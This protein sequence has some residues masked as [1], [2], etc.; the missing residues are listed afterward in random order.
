MVIKRHIR[1]NQSIKHPKRNWPP[2]L[3][4]FLVPSLLFTSYFFYRGVVPF[5]HS[6]ILTV[7]LGQQYIDFFAFYRHNLFTHPSNLLFTFSKGLGGTL[8]GTFAYYLTSP[9]NL[10]VFL[11]PESQLPGAIFVIIS[12]KIGLIGLTG[13]HYFKR[14]FN[15]KQTRIALALAVSYA[16]S[17]YVI[18]NNFNLMWLDSVILLPLLVLAVDYLVESPTIPSSGIH[19]YNLL[20]VLSLTWFTNFYTGMMIILFTTLYFLIRLC[21]YSHLKNKG[22]RWQKLRFYVVQ[23]FFS[24]MLNAVVLLPTFLELLQG[25]AKSTENIFNLNFSVQPQNLLAKLFSGSFDFDEMSQGMPNFYFGA[26]LLVFLLAYFLC[27]QFPIR[28]RLLN[29]GLIVFLLLSMCFDPL[30]LLWHSGQFPT[31]YP[32]RFSFV[33]SFFALILVAKYLEYWQSGSAKL[34][35]NKIK[36]IG[37]ILLALIT[38][39]GSKLVAFQ[40]LDQARMFIT[41]GLLIVGLLLLVYRGQLRIVTTTLLVSLITLDV[42]TNL[43]GSLQD[44]TYQDYADYINYTKAVRTATTSVNQK[45]QSL[46][47]IEKDFLRSDDDSFSSGYAGVGQFNSVIEKNQIDY[48]RDIGLVTNA[49]A[50]SN[51]FPTV[52]SDSLL[53][54]KYYLTENKAFEEKRQVASFEQLSYRPDFKLYQPVRTVG[55]INLIRNPYALPFAYLTKKEIKETLR[56]NTGRMNQEAILQ[57]ILPSNTPYFTQLTLPKATLKNFELTAEQKYKTVLPGQTGTVSFTFTPSTDAPY[58]L[59]IPH[60]LV[61]DDVKIYVNKHQINNSDLASEPKLINVAAAQKTYPIKITFEAK[62]ILD[63]NELYLYQFNLPQFKVATKRLQQTAPQIRQ[64]SARKLVSSSFHTKSRQILQTQIPVT[65][66]SG[67]WLVYDHQERIKTT[68]WNNVML[69]VPLKAG[70]HK[71]RFVYQ[72]IGLY[73]GLAISTLT[74]LVFLINAFV[75]RNPQE[76]AD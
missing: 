71:L 10:L 31:W 52:V 57:S 12:C 66:Y 46:F 32:G 21:Q 39:V 13:Y 37:L 18:T 15:F 61:K 73:Y 36:I 22:L 68:D 65:S 59:S 44:I 35:P 16:L 27:K 50:F 23:N 42:A 29:L 41:I 24:G 9:L 11:F 63:L 60:W 26:I 17:G 25:K 55:Q 3:L 38:F 34:S 19:K 8:I 47:R 75:T 53:G 4:S 43:V 64:L 40:F 33:L 6:S 76:K 1:T 58:Y 7:D 49:N 54:I 2:Y 30:I 28:E 56:S 70:A 74:L 72:P 14:R 48:L 5:G 69:Q 51:G 67:R 62:N 20:I 45:Q